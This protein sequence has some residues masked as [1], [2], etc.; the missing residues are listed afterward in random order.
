M[1]AWL[2]GSGPTG[3]YVTLG[4]VAHAL[5]VV[6]AGLALLADLVRRLAPG[7]YREAWKEASCR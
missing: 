3:W 5:L 2:G 1:Q 4:Q 6:Y 7:V